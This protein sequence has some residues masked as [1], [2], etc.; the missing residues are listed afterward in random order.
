MFIGE[1][2]QNLVIIL[3]YVWVKTMSFNIEKKEKKNYVQFTTRF[4]E[5]LL[6]NI[7]KVSKEKNIS[8]NALIN[9]CVRYALKD[10]K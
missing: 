2:I 10:M 4:E 7:K 3:K 5:E 1:Y 9:E 8:I 6:E